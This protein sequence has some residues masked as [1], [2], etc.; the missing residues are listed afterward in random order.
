M[1]FELGMKNKQ[2]ESNL[3]PIKVNEKSSK[4]NCL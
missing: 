4:V 2:L 1:H 3:G